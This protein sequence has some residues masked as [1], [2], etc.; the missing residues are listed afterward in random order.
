MGFEF[1]LNEHLT[2]RRRDVNVRA[3]IYWQN[4]VI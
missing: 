3:V 4:V 2:G 1:G